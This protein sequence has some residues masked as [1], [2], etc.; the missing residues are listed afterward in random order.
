MEESEGNAGDERGWFVKFFH[1]RSCSIIVE[2]KFIGNHFLYDGARIEQMSRKVQTWYPVLFLSELVLFPR[3]EVEI[4]VLKETFQKNFS[5]Q[6]VRSGLFAVYTINDD[7]NAD[8]GLSLFPIGTLNKVFV[9]RTG[10]VFEEDIVLLKMKTLYKIRCEELREFQGIVE[11]R[12]RI[13]NEIPEISVERW[14][15]VYDDLLFWVNHVMSSVDPRW[16]VFMGDVNRTPMESFVN[17]LCMEIPFGTSEKLYL[18]EQPNSYA[19]ALALI[20]LL[21]EV[22]IEPDASGPVQ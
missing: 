13:L 20:K 2:S 9:N 12:C 4:E 7:E 8:E 1:R 15:T 16:N 19:R 21:K 11:T 3:C 22:G 10:D 17:R 14:S 5:S 6:Y 18:L